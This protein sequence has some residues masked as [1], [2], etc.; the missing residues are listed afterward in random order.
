VAGAANPD[1]S[2]GATFVHLDATGDAVADLTIQLVGNIT[3]T[4]A[5]FIL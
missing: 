3:L 4:S 1:G 5:D 2:L